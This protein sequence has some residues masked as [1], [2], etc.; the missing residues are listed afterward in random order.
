M[1]LAGFGFLL[2]M[3]LLVGYEL[4]K[5]KKEDDEWED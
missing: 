3:I 5:E 2:F 4:W 1:V